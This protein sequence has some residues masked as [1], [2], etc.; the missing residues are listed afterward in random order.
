MTDPKHPRQP[1]PE[2][3]T[4]NRQLTTGLVALKY[5]DMRFL[6]VGKIF[7]WVSLH[8]VLV[9]I[10]YQVYDVTGDV[11]N[12]AYIGLAVFAPAFG[13]ALVT[14]YIADL[15]DRKSVIV[16]C[17]CIILISCLMFF[18][19]SLGEKE[20][21][22]PVFL[23]L[24]LIGTGRAFYQPAT[25]SLVPNLVPAAIFPNAV[26][27]HTST[28]KIAQ[29]VGPAL[30]G[31]IY[32]ISPEVVYLAA[33]A[34]MLI[35][36]LLTSLIKKKTKRENRKPT[37]WAALLCGLKYVYQKKIILGAITLDL[38][39]VLLGGVTALLPVFAKD[40][41]DVGALGAGLM[42]SAIAIGSLATGLALTQV[43]IKRSVGKILYIS[44]LVFG[45]AT[46]LFG[47]STVFWLSMVAMV[48]VGIGDMVSVYIRVTLVQIATPD[49]MR[50]RVSAVN[51]VF[52]GASNEI[53]EFRAGMMANAIGA[54]PAVLF[55]GIG[56]F[57]I[58]GLCWAAFP[59]LR[60]VQRMDR[61]L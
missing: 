52:T 58:A 2:E 47:L 51:S 8:M 31:I 50:G 56:C 40:I 3:N 24:G 44:V 46:I 41:L 21:I 48:I 18:W 34:G 39:V 28:N 35:G 30:G 22:W 60:R 45:G 27:W 1:K 42:R 4:K 13:F 37:S 9:A 32:L 36:A 12:L 20:E 55:G 17:Y 59:E 29:M 10:A 57:L 14:G 16:I 23:I 15:F 49:E 43:N 6:I 7:G 61:E 54:I 38:F 25:N 11:K 33:A 19:W 53:G 5:R 26:A